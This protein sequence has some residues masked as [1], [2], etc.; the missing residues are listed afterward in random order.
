MAST[1]MAKPRSFAEFSVAGGTPACNAIPL[2]MLWRRRCTVGMLTAALVV[3][4]TN[5]LDIG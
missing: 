1:M 4:L 5:V 3:G 2:R